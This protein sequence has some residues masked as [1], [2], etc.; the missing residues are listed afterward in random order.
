MAY[1]VDGLKR[2]FM[3]DNKKL[4]DIPNMSLEQ[5]KDFYSNQFPELNNANISGPEVKE[6]VLVYTF[7]NKIGTKG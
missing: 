1:T 3:H 7:S 6:N 4:E 5:I 2:I